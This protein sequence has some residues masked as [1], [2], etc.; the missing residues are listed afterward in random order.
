MT[1]E[2]RPLTDPDRRPCEIGPLE[3]FSDEIA[4]EEFRREPYRRTERIGIVENGI[5][6][7]SA[8]VRSVFYSRC[9]GWAKPPTSEEFYRA[10]RNPTPTEREKAVIWTWI[11]EAPIQCWMA[12]WREGAYSWRMLARAFKLSGND[13][14]E[15]M[16]IL[17]TF[18]ARPELI[19]EDWLPWLEK[20]PEVPEAT[21]YLRR[22][23]EDA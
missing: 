20:R 7:E 11:D 17:N 8:A 18:A 12:A 15:R 13:A 19:D 1:K 21:I 10:V 6:E 23:E 5:K 22:S 2:F 3:A 16:R 9:C 4:P 14:Y